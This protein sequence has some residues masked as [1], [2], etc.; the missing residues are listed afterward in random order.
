M[1][2]GFPPFVASVPV[3]HPDR[4]QANVPTTLSYGLEASDELRGIPRAHPVS[5]DE[6]AYLRSKT[7]WKKDLGH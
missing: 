2:L 7:S 6:T 3:I 4:T 1:S 5:G